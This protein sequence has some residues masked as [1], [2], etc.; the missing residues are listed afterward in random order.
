MKSIAV[1]GAGIAGLTLAGRLKG[2]ARVTVFEKSGGFGGRMATRRAG[3]FQFD[4]GAQYFTARSTEFRQFLLD[5]CSEK[6]LSDWQPRTITLDGQEKPYSRPWFEPHWIGVPGMTSLGKE[7]SLGQQ[8][9][10]QTKV[11]RI[12]PTTTGWTIEL[13]SGL[14]HGP[15]DWIVSTAPAPQT[16]ILFPAAFQHHRSLEQVRM[17]ACFSLMLGYQADLELPFQAA[18]VKNSPLGWLAIDSSKPG[19]S[20]GQSLLVQSTNDWA[21]TQLQEPAEHVQNSMLEAL[22]KLLPQLPEA[23]H[24]DIHRWL[25]AATTSAAGQDYLMDEKQH[26]AACGDWCLGGRVEAAFTSADR[27]AAALADRLQ[28]SST[29][30]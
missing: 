22:H 23:T 19:R 27:L 11:G 18:K 12:S 5:H 13:E 28:D 30:S 7:L 16:S 15:F 9:E 17:S 24:V 2:L 3:G 1:I 26:L 25:Y 29:S 10:L 20:G 21:D 6:A 14:Q 4:H 8:V